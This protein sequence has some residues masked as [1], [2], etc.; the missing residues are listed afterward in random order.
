[1]KRKQFIKDTISVLR[2][3]NFDG[4]DL[5]RIRRWSLP[6]GL[7]C[8]VTCW[9]LGVSRG[10][11]SHRLHGFGQGFP[12]GVSEWS[13][14]QRQTSATTYCCSRRLEAKNNSGLWAGYHFPVSLVNFQQHTNNTDF[15]AFVAL[16]YLDLINIM[17]Y[18]YHGILICFTWKCDFEDSLLG[19]SV[20]YTV[21][22][23]Y[24]M[25][26]ITEIFTFK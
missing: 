19:P 12:I 16:R 9:R 18:D 20:C 14:Y 5:G 6:L 4:L 25:A 24:E 23:L 26:F 8:N 22:L 7:F 1:M 11:G 3:Y 21:F 13:V 10:F 2:K 17:A 15:E